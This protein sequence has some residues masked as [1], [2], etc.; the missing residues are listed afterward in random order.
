MTHSRES[1]ILTSHSLTS[2]FIGETSGVAYFDF[3]LMHCKMLL[4]TPART[5]VPAVTG[6]RV[7]REGKGRAVAAPAPELFSVELEKEGMKLDPFC[8]F[9]VDRGV[10]RSGGRQD[11]RSLALPFRPRQ[12]D[13]KMLTSE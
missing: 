8:C 7:T 1:D 5:A 4:E 6:R 3:Q 12:V 10:R 2:H 11:A 13:K 9:A